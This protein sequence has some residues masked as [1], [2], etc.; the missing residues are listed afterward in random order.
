MEKMMK[1]YIKPLLVIAGVLVTI[2]AEAYSFKFHNNLW[3]DFT[4][5]MKLLGLF[6]NEETIEVPANGRGERSFDGLRAGLAP[7]YIK[8]V[9]TKNSADRI[10]PRRLCV[11]RAEFDRVIKLYGNMWPVD[12]VF[13]IPPQQCPGIGDMEF[14]IVQDA[15]SGELILVQ[16]STGIGGI[17]RGLIN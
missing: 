1:L 8:L 10:D 2:Q 13:Q 3:Q 12:A 17:V 9:K 11:P 14:E 15:N 7:E 6:E 16:I 4:V 5:K